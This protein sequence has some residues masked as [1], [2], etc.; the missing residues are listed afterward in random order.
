[1]STDYKIFAEYK[2]NGEWKLFS[3]K[4]SYGENSY[5][6]DYF[7]ER[8]VNYWVSSHWTGKIV[9]S[10]LSGGGILIEDISD[11][12]EFAFDHM[13]TSYYQLEKLNV[14]LYMLKDDSDKEYLFE[15]INEFKNVEDYI[16]SEYKPDDFRLVY[17]SY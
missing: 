7:T 5:T 9:R 17:I 12:S 4:M 2:V 16:R 3:D 14:E 8:Q 13:S 6:S 11:D 15:V 1:M 10:L